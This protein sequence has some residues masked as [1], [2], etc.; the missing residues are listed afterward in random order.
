MN[1]M[2]ITLTKTDTDFNRIYG[3]AKIAERKGDHYVWY[4]NI[5]HCTN[6]HC[7]ASDGHVLYKSSLYNPKFKGA[8]DRQFLPTSVKKHEVILEE[9]LGD[10]RVP[11]PDIS[12]ITNS[13]S[14]CDN[15]G[16]LPVDSTVGL[17][18]DSMDI[19]ISIL[20]SE[21]VRGLKQGLSLSFLRFSTIVKLLLK[22]Q[23]WTVYYK[24]DDATPI[25]F[26]GFELNIYLL[27][28][29]TKSK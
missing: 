10:D 13:I 3:C 21:V 23:V 15:S 28:I 12:S 26:E 14:D 18:R 19:N 9:V 22:G 2:T 7:M 4:R 8:E 24:S 20:Y 29:S 11:F 5:I 27:P 17:D 16:W 6:T 25:M 1:K